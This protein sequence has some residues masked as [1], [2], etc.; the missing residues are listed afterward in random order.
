LANALNLK[1]TLLR[2]AASSEELGAMPG[3]ERS[4]GTAG[5]HF[6]SFDDM[7][8]KISEQAVNYLE[9]LADSLRQ[10]GVT[11]VEQRIIRGPAD[12]M[13]VDVALETPDNLV[14]MTTHGRPGQARWTLGSVTDR[15]V[16]HSGDPVLV[17]RTA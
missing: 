2:T 7:A 4:D 16:R 9:G 15:V 3:Y 5:L 6:Q 13:I 11:K 1:V 12:E 10:Q 14:A 8:K 17:I